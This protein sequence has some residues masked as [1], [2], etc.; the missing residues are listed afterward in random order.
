LVE[1]CPS[2]FLTIPS[3]PITISYGFL[4]YIRIR[5]REAILLLIWPDPDSSWAFCCQTFKFLILNGN[6]F[7]FES[8]IKN[9]K[10]PGHKILGLDGS[11]YLT[12]VSGDNPLRKI[13]D[14]SLFVQQ[15]PAA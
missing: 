9:G 1:I 14:H 4:Q 3:E 7:F 12:L 15:L 11:G 2:L 13:Y 6:I 8:L 10:D 5:I